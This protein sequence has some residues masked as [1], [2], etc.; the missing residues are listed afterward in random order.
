MTLKE[1]WM[2]EN[3]NGD[4][5]EYKK[6]NC[7]P[8]MEYASCQGMSCTDCWNREIPEEEPVKKDEAP[9]VAY[10]CDQKAC[11][12]CTYPKCRY[13]TD[14]EHAVNFKSHLNITE[15][16]EYTKYMEKDKDEDTSGCHTQT[17]DIAVAYENLKVD[18][19][20]L[21]DDN[22]YLQDKVKHLETYIRY[23]NGEITF[24]RKC[25]I[26]AVGGNKNDA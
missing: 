7:P 15:D 6:H 3:P 4:F 11:E 16:C 2:L 1:K 8:D 22:D 21:L 26:T 14:I 17:I 24:L 5:Y 9:R 18:R 12:N 20:Q 10:L 19:D 25:L 23:L 13:T